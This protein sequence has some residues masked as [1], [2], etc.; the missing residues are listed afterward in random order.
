MA[1]VPWPEEAKRAF[2]D[3]QFRLQTEHYDTHFADA[4]F[5]IV[6]RTHEPIGRLYVHEGPDTTYVMDITLLPPH[7]NQGI[8]TALMRQVIQAARAG[9]RRVTCHVEFNNPAKRLYERLGFERTGEHGV[10][11]EM[12]LRAPQPPTLS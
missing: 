11:F 6:E 10:Y 12:E 3:D 4:Q 7:R 8:G 1:V 2:L 9:G 5:H